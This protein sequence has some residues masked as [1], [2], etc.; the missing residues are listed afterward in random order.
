MDAACPDPFPSAS[1]VGHASKIARQLS[2]ART[3]READN[4]LSRAVHAHCRQMKHAGSARV[5]EKS[6]AGAGQRG[7]R[8]RDR[9]TR[10]TCLSKRNLIPA[11][12]GT[13]VT[14]LCFNRRR[15]QL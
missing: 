15:H 12:S 6:P 14:L 13:I 11:Y 4:V 10:S 2:K 1:R 9:G 3:N 7:H 5:G 8:D